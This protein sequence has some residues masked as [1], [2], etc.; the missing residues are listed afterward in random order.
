[1][2]E[3]FYIRFTRRSGFEK[4]HCFLKKC[5]TTSEECQACPYLT[6]NPP[7]KEITI[8]GEPGVLFETPEVNRVTWHIEHSET[9]RPD[10]QAIRTRLPRHERGRQFTLDA[11]GVIT[12]KHDETEW[13]PPKDIPGYQR[14]SDKPWRF[15][16]LWPKCMKR[17]PESKRSAGCGCIELRM[18]CE[19]EEAPLIG[20]FVTC[21]QCQACE[22][23]VEI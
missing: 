20:Q 23:R 18:K 12:Y 16:P 5:D 7:G 14:D 11:S 22:R 17:Q 2:T 10:L 13:E 4:R 21:E 1:V 8:N 19:C 15:V 6:V 9:F 3:C